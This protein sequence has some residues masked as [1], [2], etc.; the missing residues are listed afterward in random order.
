[1]KTAQTRLDWREGRRRRAWELKQ[2]GWNQTQSAAGWGVTS[3]A[4]SQWLTR[5]RVEGVEEGLRAPPAS[6]RPSQLTP[7][8]R[9]QLPAVLD[10]G[11]AA[12]GL[13]GQGW[14]C[15]RGGAVI[16]HAFGVPSDP[17]PGGRLVQTLGSSVPRPLARASDA[18]GRGGHSGRVGASRAGAQKKAPDEDRRL[19]GRDPSGVSLLPHQGRTGA[20]GSQTP[21]L[22]VPLTRAH[23]AASGALSPDRRRFL[24]T[25][26]GAYHRPAV[27]GVLRVRRRTIPGTLLIMW[28]GA[29]RHRGPP[30]Q[31]FL[32]RGAAKRIHLEPLPG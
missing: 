18:A 23:R 27:V 4:V 22:P 17:S 25:Q 7:D 29:P 26:P 31:D 16:R 24:Q 20:R 3:G 12:D 32:A 9:A 5:A 1:M 30:S 10:R 13:R 19:V 6:G 28:D 2:A 11:A 14:R 15:Q 8:Q 21:L